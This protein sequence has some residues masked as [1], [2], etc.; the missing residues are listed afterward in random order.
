VSTGEC[1]N[2]NR[3]V[4]LVFAVFI[5]QVF[6]LNVSADYCPGQKGFADDAC[7]DENGKPILN[8]KPSKTYEILEAT[9]KP[10]PIFQ[11][12][13][14]CWASIQTAN[15]MCLEGTSPK[16]AAGVATINVLLSGVSAMGLTEACSKYRKAMDVATAAMSAFA[17]QCAYFKYQC[18]KACHAASKAVGSNTVLTGFGQTVSSLTNTNLAAEKQWLSRATTECDSYQLQIASA[19]AGLINLLKKSSEA[20]QCEDAS[21]GD[22]EI[23]CNKSENANNAKCICERTGN[24]APG[25]PGANTANAGGS[26]LSSVSTSTN[27]SSLQ[28][29]N[30][31]NKFT[32][33]EDRNGFGDDELRKSGSSGS[34][35]GGSGSMGGGDG[36]SG[37]GSGGSGGSK[38]SKGGA[39]SGKSKGLNPNILSGEYGGGGGG[40]FRGRNGYDLPANSAYRA[41]MPGGAKDPSRATASDSKTND[42]TGAGGEDNWKKVSNRYRDNRPKLGD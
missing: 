5:S 27:S 38:G 15:K 26:S 23:D 12:S 7:Y 28:K 22:K 10:K 25:C 37:G 2:C 17:A 3:F 16:I 4:L 21:K 8:A 29:N 1:M 24:T 13:E 36:I 32:T 20:K 6:S 14:A 9:Y 40:G 42:V 30:S 33:S 39:D 11:N 35:P 19:G 18:D 34:D 31:Q 41:Y